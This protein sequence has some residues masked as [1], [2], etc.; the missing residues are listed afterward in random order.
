MRDMNAMAADVVRT[1]REFV[2]RALVSVTERLDALEQRVAAIPAGAKGDPGGPGEPGPVGPVGA[3]GK[4]GRPGE[5][6]PAG[7]QGK[8]GEPGKPID[9]ETL[10]KL[11]NTLVA[12][13]LA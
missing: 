7:P 12:K 10:T 13:L 8:Q 2:A 5:T 6:G 4:D 9:P 3:N 11:A 1:M